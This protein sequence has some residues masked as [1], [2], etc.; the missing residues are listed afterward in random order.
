V[1]KK[2]WSVNVKERDYSEELGVDGIRIDL[3]ELG[4]EEVD[5]MH[6]AQDRDHWQAP[7]NTVMNLRVP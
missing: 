4:W 3:K 5:W 6:M 1:Y 7:L 2:L